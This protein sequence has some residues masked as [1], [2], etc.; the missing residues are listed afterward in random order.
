MIEIALATLIFALWHSLLASLPVKNRVAGALHARS[1]TYR[2][3]FMAQSAVTFGALLWLIFSRP[4][5]TIY[6]FEGWKKLPFWLAQGFFAGVCLWSVWELAPARF[7]LGKIDDEPETQSPDFHRNDENA[8]RGPFRWSRHPLEWAPVL[9]L[10]CTPHLKTNWLAFNILGAFYAFLA[11]CMRN[12]LGNQSRQTVC[13]ISGKCQI[14]LR[15][16]AR[17]R[18]I[19]ARI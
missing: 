16:L 10:C 12:V 11:R 17:N 14:F 13:E 4:K 7:V 1:W 8:A 9:I 2:G 15:A 19:R 3:F 5:R 6:R 18:R